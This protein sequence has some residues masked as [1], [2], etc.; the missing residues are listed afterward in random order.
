MEAVHKKDWRCTN[1]C[2]KMFAKECFMTNKPFWRSFFRRD[3]QHK[4]QTLNRPCLQRVLQASPPK[5]HYTGTSRK[6]VERNLRNSPTSASPATH[7]KH[8][9]PSVSVCAFWFSFNPQRNTLKESNVNTKQNNTLLRTSKLTKKN[10]NLK[11][12]TP[13]FL[14]TTF[15][16]LNAPGNK[17]L[18]T[19]TKQAR[20]IA[21]LAL[22]RKN[23]TGGLASWP[24][25]LV[26]KMGCGQTM[27]VITRA[28]KA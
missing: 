15:P 10:C 13:L 5:F 24:L 1:L 25:T 3:I 17:T 23:D 11:M 28:S 27:R 8:H 21:S 9:T 6:N 26:G 4:A 20:N 16:N 14:S 7:F 18:E 19:A 2:C 22:T 12:G